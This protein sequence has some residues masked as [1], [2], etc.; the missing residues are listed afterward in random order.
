MAL[1]ELLGVTTPD[2]G[3]VTRHLLQLYQAD[4]HT[5][6]MPAEQH[7]RHI[8]FFTEHTTLLQGS[9]SSLLQDLQQHV[10]LWEDSGG[11]RTATE[12]F[13][14]LGADT[15]ELQADVVG[16]GMHFVDSIYQTSSSGVSSAVRKQLLGVLGVQKPNKLA[17]ARYLVQ[18]HRDTDASAITE[19]QRCRHLAFLADNVQLLEPGSSMGGDGSASLL[20]TAQQHLHL[21]AVDDS[22]LPAKQLWFPP[23]AD[24][25]D[26]LPDLAAAGMRFV[27]ARYSSSQSSSASSR[28][29]EKVLELLELLLVDHPSCADIA[30]CLRL[31]EADSKAVIEEQRSRHLA[32]IAANLHH[33]PANRKP[34]LLKRLQDSLLLQDS[35]GSYRLAGDLLFSLSPDMANLQASMDAAGM[36]FLHSSYTDAAASAGSKASS[37]QRGSRQSL[38][39]LLFE[40]GVQEADAN[41]VAAHI[42]KLYPSAADAS[43]STDLLPFDQHMAHLQFFCREWG[44]LATN[45]KEAV[46][47]NLQLRLQAGCSRAASTAAAARNADSCSPLLLLPPCHTSLTG[48][49]QALQQGGALFLSDEYT[50]AAAGLQARDWS[51]LQQWFRTGLSAELLSDER[52]ANFILSA[53]QQADFVGKCSPQQLIQQGLYVAAVSVKLSASGKKHQAEAI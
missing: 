48:M 32:F 20:E 50:S 49:L 18:L 3:V 14:S 43:N 46:C 24:K 8:D 17:V 10:L 28:K 19:R 47:Q 16:A 41:T 33:L 11:R 25:A 9:E 27:H 36:P 1:L 42:L 34:G 31:H 37:V 22:Y 23:E 45:T 51:E 6:A 15:A 26:L 4:E 29:A 12:L 53:H 35:A 44:S 21:Q 40:L 52:A 2:F 39:E 5:A 7:M 13:F 30:E 38:L